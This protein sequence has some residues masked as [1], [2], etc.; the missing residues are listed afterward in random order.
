MDQES[1]CKPFK[2]VDEQIDILVSRGLKV[3]DKEYASRVLADVN[4]YRLSAYSLTYRKDDRFYNDVSFEDIVEIYE[5]DAAFRALI[6]EFSQKIEA[7]LRAQ[8]AYIHSKKYGPLGYLER[9]NFV[10]ED[11]Y[12]TFIGRHKELIEKSREA[13]INHHKKKRQNIF[14]L[15]VSVEVM[16]F[17]V[18]SKCICNMKQEDLAELCK[19][20][21]FHKRFMHSW[22]QCAVI[23][24][25]IAAHGGRFYNRILATKVCIPTEHKGKIPDN[26]TFGYVYAIYRLLAKESDRQEF[27]R[28]IEQTFEKYPKALPKHL[29]F[30]TNWRTILS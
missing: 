28:R 27:V 13:F 29:G 10:C 20:Y 12:K 4:Y 25:N 24:R 9:D 7:S 19:Y 1:V 18:L 6:V 3:V 30:P 2:T 23:A 16:T 8:F 15:W 14:P 5:F 26:R 21:G 11:A 22:I 17:D